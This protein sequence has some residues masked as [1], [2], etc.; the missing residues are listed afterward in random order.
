MTTDIHMFMR[1]Y[2]LTQAKAL[3]ALKDQVK[4]AKAKA[5]T[6]GVHLV[7]INSFPIVVLTFIFSIIYVISLPLMSVLRQAKVVHLQQLPRARSSSSSGSNS[8]SSRRRRRRK[9]ASAGSQAQPSAPPSSPCVSVAASKQLPPPAKA[10][11]Q[12]VG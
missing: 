11:C 3:A 12:H 7:L 1:T 8:S 6:N 5:A 2:I 4:V 10:H 9:R